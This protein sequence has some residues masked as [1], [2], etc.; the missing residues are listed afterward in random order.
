MRATGRVIIGAS[1]GDQQAMEGYEGHGVFTYTLLEALRGLA[2]KSGNNDG[3]LTVNE[4]AEYIGDRVPKIT[5]ERWGKQQF[6][7]QSLQGRSF[8][9]ALTH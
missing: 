6:P 3:Q 5:Q 4:L 8:P 1:A 9:I 7:M 2:D